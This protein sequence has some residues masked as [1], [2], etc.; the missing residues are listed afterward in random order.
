MVKGADRQVRNLEAA[1]RA[2]EASIR[3][4]REELVTLGTGLVLCESCKLRVCSEC[5]RRLVGRR[6]DAAT[7]SDRCRRR[8]ARRL[9]GLAMV[10]DADITIAG[11]GNALDADELRA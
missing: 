7:C 3:R 5:T 4:M 11:E 10:G 8:R 2:S 1:L 9:R 6:A